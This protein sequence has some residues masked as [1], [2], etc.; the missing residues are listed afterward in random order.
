MLSR[1]FQPPTLVATGCCHIGYLHAL[2]WLGGDSYGDYQNVW[3]FFLNGVD[4]I[5][6]WRVN[7]TS[8]NDVSRIRYFL[9]LIVSPWFC[10]LMALITHVSPI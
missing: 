1:R 3:L 2:Y 8:D 4:D 9:M 5:E 7:E 10:L 6:R